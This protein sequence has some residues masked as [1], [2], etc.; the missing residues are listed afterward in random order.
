MTLD[1]SYDN[2]LERYYAHVRAIETDT[3]NRPW[4]IAASR[5][6]YALLADIE[7]D[8]GPAAPMG[9]AH[10]MTLTNHELCQMIRR[11]A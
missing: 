10:S 11:A 7:C 2:T 3:A 4:H 6:L 9:C 5:G 1:E 8:G